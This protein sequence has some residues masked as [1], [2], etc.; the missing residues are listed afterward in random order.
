MSARILPKLLKEKID[1]LN[2]ELAILDVREQ[3]LFAENHLL[4]ASNTPLS[5]LEIEAPRLVPR[6]SCPIVLCDGGDNHK[7]HEVT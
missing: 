6:A 2:Q 1:K 4:F 3:G 7:W 5:R